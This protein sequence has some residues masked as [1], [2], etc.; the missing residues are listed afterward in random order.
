MEIEM[1]ITER[2]LFGPI[3]PTE[4]SVFDIR[5]ANDL[6]DKI[7][8]SE[9]EMDKIKLKQE[10]DRYVWDSKIAEETK[11]TIKFGDRTKKMLQKQIEKFNSQEKISLALLEIFEK[12]DLLPDNLKEVKE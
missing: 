7:N 3:L 6:R 1:N 11:K 4:G 8:L 2:I 10:K 12:F 9:A 5:L